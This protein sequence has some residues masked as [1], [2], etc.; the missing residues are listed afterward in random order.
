MAIELD[1]GHL[2]Q[3]IEQTAISALGGSQLND[4]WSSS[5][6]SVTTR[7]KQVFGD[8]GKSLGYQIAASGYPGA[9][10]GEWLYDMVWYVVGPAGMYLRQAMVLES[11]PNL[12]T[13]DLDDH[14]LKLV[15]ARANV[16][17]WF[18][19]VQ[20]HEQHIT[21]CKRQASVFSNGALGDAYLFVVWNSALRRAFVE[22]FHVGWP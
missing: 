15:Q 18:T 2:M 14:F 17:V 4:L 22:Q 8:L 10:G 16:R 20:S 19:A 1:P 3:K 12:K 6:G 7:V 9:D 21:N 11:E 5:F 13:D